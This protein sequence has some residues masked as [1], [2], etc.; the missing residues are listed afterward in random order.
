[1]TVFLGP[2]RGILHA[3]ERDRKTMRLSKLTSAGLALAAFSV[4]PLSSQAMTLEEAVNSTMI[5][6]PQIQRDEALERA[7]DQNIEESYARYLPRVDL[8]AST[9]PQ[10][11]NSPVTRGA[12]NEGILEWRSD[13]LARFTQMIMDGGATPSLVAAARASRRGA[14]G[15]LQETAE[16]V[17]ID[18][19]QFYLDVLRNQDFVR[20]TEEN[21]VAHQELVD[22]VSGLVQAGRGS[23]A[24]NAQAGSRL[25]LASA[26]L[27]D[28]RGQLREVVARFTETVGEEPS[29]LAMPVVP[30]YGEP[31]TLDEAIAI[32]MEMNPSVI[33]TAARVDQT[34]HEVGE[35]EAAYYPR[36]D[37]EVFGGVNKDQDGVRG[38]DSDLNL[39]ARAQMN[40]FNGFGDLARV[41]RA[42]MLH[43]A[44]KGTLGDESRRVREETR[45]VWYSLVTARDRVVPLREHASTQQRVLDSYRGQFDVGRR[46]LLDL[47][48][49]QNEYYQAQ[50]TLVDAEFN[51]IVAQYE[52]IF[53]TGRLLD[54]LG[55]VVMSDEDD[56]LTREE[57]MG[58]GAM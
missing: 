6:H 17:A 15:D 40:L 27:E 57:L 3:F 50:T 56:H 31:A 39:R 46:T 34:E 51:V 7:A 29:D 55:V 33:A 26:T 4:A 58:K 30:D 28:R 49:A 8:D 5:F 22:L 43:N 14:T 45:T 35:F 38:Y 20:L 52:L 37:V 1:M 41:R 10:V 36:L 16:L 32:A 21:V 2:F 44:A 9:G 11:T 47:L 13:S 12:G 23:E 54:V 19:V 42:E 53:V 24:D 18:A 48:D 25:A